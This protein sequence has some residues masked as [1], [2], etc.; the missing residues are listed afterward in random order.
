MGWLGEG[1]DNSQ[2]GVLTLDRG[3]RAELAIVPYGQEHTIKMC[4]QSQDPE[5]GTADGEGV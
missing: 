1:L 2:N 4:F 5:D 3:M